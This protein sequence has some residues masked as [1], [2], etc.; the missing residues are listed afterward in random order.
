LSEHL[1]KCTK[2]NITYVS[3][4]IGCRDCWQSDGIVHM[5]SLMGDRF[6]DFKNKT[7]YEVMVE[8]E[9]IRK[10]ENE[11][12]EFCGSSNVSVEK[13]AVNDIPLYSFDKLVD[14][15]K[16]TDS[17]MLIINIDKKELNLIL[18]PGGSVKCTPMF[19]LKA[20]GKITEIVN[21]SPDGYFQSQTKGNF[22]ACVFGNNDSVRIE[23]LGTGGITREEII[24]E[25][26][27]FILRLM[28][29]SRPLL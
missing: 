7:E 20:V 4:S 8:L 22:N 5:Y 27:A 16:S 15:C 17:Q 24:T 12:C 1:I 13:I 23:R 28:K 2:M 29:P 6:L 19:L 25:I 9:D 11:Q 18:K 21:K 3:C 26:K 10:R 14:K